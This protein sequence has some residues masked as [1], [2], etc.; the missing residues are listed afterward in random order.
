[1]K[2]AFVVDDWI[3][4]QLKFVFLWL[5]GLSEG[6]QVTVKDLGDTCSH[7]IRGGPSER[8]QEASYLPGRGRRV[9]CL[10]YKQENREG[11]GRDS[12][13]HSRR[14]PMAQELT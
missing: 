9:P 7:L 8:C 4:A 6:L 5:M 1:M 10:G 12:L 3:T 13:S 14:T 11:M 2:F